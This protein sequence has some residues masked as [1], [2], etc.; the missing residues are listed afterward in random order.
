[1]LEIFEIRDRGLM[2]APGAPDRLAIEAHIRSQ[3]HAH[4][5]MVRTRYDD[6]GFSGGS[7]D[8]CVPKT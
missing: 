4:W 1:M 6:G 3:A 8:L 7:T 5:T 2:R